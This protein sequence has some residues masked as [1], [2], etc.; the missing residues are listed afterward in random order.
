MPTIY[1]YVAAIINHAVSATVL[2]QQ[3]R[4][5]VKLF[6]WGIWRAFKNILLRTASG[7]VMRSD[8]F[9]DFGAI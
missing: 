7:A 6:L 5:A 2:I 4:N 8:S 1:W 3:L 9:V